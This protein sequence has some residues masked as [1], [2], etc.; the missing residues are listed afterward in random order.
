[1]TALTKGQLHHFKKRLLDMKASMQTE[2][3]QF[4]ALDQDD[5]LEQL[6]PHT[7]HPADAATTQY[8]NEF[9]QGMEQFAKD[10]LQVIEDAL[11]KIENGTYGFSEVSG[12]PIPIER[13]EALPTARNL[14][15]EETT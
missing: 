13:L 9:N 6:S 12:K 10:Q 14:T 5:D 15:N 4:A 11:Q 7:N 3:N 8:E 1:M 2:A